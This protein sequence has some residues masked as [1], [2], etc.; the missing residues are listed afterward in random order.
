MEL[1][2]TRH[3]GSKPRTEEEIS[4]KLWKAIVALLEKLEQ[5]NFFSEAYPEGC[6]D[7]ASI[8]CG[9]D[10]DKLNAEIELRTNLSWP[11][12]ITKDSEHYWQDREPYIPT[13]YEIFDLLEL[14]FHRTS[15]PEEGQYH[16]YGRH[17]HLHFPANNNAKTTFGDEL[18]ILFSATGSIYQFN[19]SN[20]QI[21]NIVGEDTQNLMMDALRQSSVMDAQY[22]QMLQTACSRI[23][24]ARLEVAY[25]ALEKLWDAYER[26]K[27]YFE[28]HDKNMKKESVAKIV[29]LFEENALFKD[30]V[31]HEM[32]KLT[33]LGN[34]FRIRHS[35]PYQFTLSSHRQINYLFRRCLAMIVLIQDQIIIVS[36]RNNQN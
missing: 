4:H 34:A 30:E 22:H 1:Y 9:T 27:C 18:N 3:L 26:L 14:L 31:N 25:E 20:G 13:K 24:H 12:K 36:Q 11:L 16:P 5:K 21:E 19:S 28:P 2:S 35:E 6:C 23:T 17:Y 10:I 33:E 29:A 32:R 7:D 8:V 15:T